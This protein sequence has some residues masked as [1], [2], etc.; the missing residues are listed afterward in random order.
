MTVGFFYFLGRFLHLYRSICGVIM[1]ATSQ[2]G[3]RMLAFRRPF[4]YPT[5]YRG[6]ELWDTDKLGMLSKKLA[7]ARLE[8]KKLRDS[9]GWGTGE[10]LRDFVRDFSYQTTDGIEV[11]VYREAVLSEDNL[12]RA[13]LFIEEYK[14]HIYGPNGSG[15]ITTFDGKIY[16]HVPW[17]YSIMGLFVWFPTA[18]YVKRIP[19]SLVDEICTRI[20]NKLISDVAT[21]KSNLRYK[22]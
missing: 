8:Y 14:V 2:K 7:L 5:K 11:K 21:M 22:D 17:H 20:M 10:P 16:V 4:K 18:I 15:G 1:L 3:L 6:A 19:A 12:S 13:T 9:E